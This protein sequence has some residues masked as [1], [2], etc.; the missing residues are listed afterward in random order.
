MTAGT[1]KFDR[2]SR[3]PANASRAANWSGN[4][5]L[6]TAAEHADVFL[7]WPDTVAAV[8]GTVAEMTSLA[9]ARDR[10]LRYGLRTHVIVRETEGEAM[11]AAGPGGS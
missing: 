2:H 11:D 1:L 10:E 6:R 9:E 4:E 8:G 3:V 7:T 5:P